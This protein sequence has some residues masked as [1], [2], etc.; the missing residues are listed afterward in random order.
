[1]KFVGTFRSYVLEPDEFSV[2][3]AFLEGRDF[4]FGESIIDIL[5]G[6]VPC[7]RAYPCGDGRTGVDVFEGTRLHEAMLQYESKRTTS[8][9]LAAA[10][11][12]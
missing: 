8:L 5:G 4:T 2:L 9:S 1:M 11:T 7:G 10:D 3:R 6:S 12:L